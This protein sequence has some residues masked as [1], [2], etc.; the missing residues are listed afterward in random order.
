MSMELIVLIGVSLLVLIGLLT[1]QV[2]F[3]RLTERIVTYL[4]P[5]KNWQ[6][7]F[8][9]HSRAFTLME[10][11][12]V[13][14]IIVILASMLLPSLQRARGK[15]KYARWQGIKRSN[16]F[17]PDCVGYWTFERDTLRDSDGDGNLDKVKNLAEGCSE[18]YYKPRKIDGAL[19]FPGTGGVIVDRGRFGKGTLEFDGDDYVN[20]GNDS[21]LSLKT[22]TIEAWFKYLADP[23]V[24]AYSTLVQKDP[25]GYGTNDN[26]HLQVKKSDHYLYAQVGDGTNI[27]T[28]TG[29]STAVNDNKWHHAVLAFVDGVSGQ[30]Y[31]DGVPG[32]LASITISACQNTGDVSIGVWYYHPPPEHPEWPYDQFYGYF[33]GIIDEV[34]IYNRVLTESE[35]KQ[36]YR[37]GKP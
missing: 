26:Y 10:L 30:V 2:R 13:I 6:K 32:A 4:M 7:V 20:C 12:V 22:F 14:T 31:V 35:I 3:E 29:P 18:K 33:N 11:L 15:A 21:S 17:D 5:I 24:Y 37:A 16:Q 27:A 8:A 9:K 19:H 34:A 1:R 25:T 36:H 28:I 23:T